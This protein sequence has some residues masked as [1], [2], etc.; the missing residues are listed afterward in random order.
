MTVYN[1][2]EK[3]KKTSNKVIKNFQVLELTK[4][5]KSFLLTFIMAFS[6]NKLFICSLIIV[7]YKKQ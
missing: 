5:K 6:I 4:S 7:K 2:Q 3:E 1:L